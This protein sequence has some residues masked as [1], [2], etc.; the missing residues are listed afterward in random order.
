[1]F[2]HE[3]GS[4]QYLSPS[5][6]EVDRD[7]GRWLRSYFLSIDNSTTGRQRLVIDANVG[8]TADHHATDL[9]R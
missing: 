8:H 3:T 2:I 4:G 6:P 7:S 5:R 1:M 9:D